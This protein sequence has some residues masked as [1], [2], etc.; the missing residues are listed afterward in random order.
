VQLYDVEQQTFIPLLTI[1]FSTEEEAKW[2]LEQS[3]WLTPELNQQHFPSHLRGG[4]A[5]VLNGNQ[6]YS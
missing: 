3:L 1:G 6:R 4:H 2:L 5:T